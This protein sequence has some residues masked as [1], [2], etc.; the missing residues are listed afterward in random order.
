MSGVSWGAEGGGGL[1][2]SPAEPAAPPSLACICHSFHY[3]KRLLETLFVHRFSHGT[4]PLRNI[5]KV[6]ALAAHPPLRRA[7][8]WPQARPPP[9]PVPFPF[10]TALTTGASLRGWPITSTTL[11]TRPPVS[12]LHPAPQEPPLPTH[13]F[14]PHHCPSASP[15]AYGAQQVKLALAIFVVRRLGRMR[16]GEYLGAPD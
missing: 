6:S 14:S 5:F 8:R 7:T 10:R 12:G 11:S 4:M 1:L 15:P 13:R 3:V 2:G 9:P 16:G